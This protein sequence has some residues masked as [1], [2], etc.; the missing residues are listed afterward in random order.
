M[1][2][3]RFFSTVEESCPAQYQITLWI[4][5]VNTE[6][7]R[8]PEESIVLGVTRRQALDMAAKIINAVSRVAD[9]PDH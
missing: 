8:D 4:G 5:T 2:V 9:I 6:N 3:L 7:T 1:K